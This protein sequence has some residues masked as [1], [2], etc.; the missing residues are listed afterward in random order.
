MHSS[1]AL[2]H[3]GHRAGADR[4]WL[5]LCDHA[6]HRI[7]AELGDLGLPAAEIC[8]HIG[9]DIGAL[10]LAQAIAAELQA[11]I[12]WHGWS[13]LV[14]DPNRHPHSADVVI[15]ESDGTPIPANLQLD[16]AA[17]DARIARYHTPYHAVIDAYLQAAKSA[18]E[19]PT[20]LA[21][22]SMTPR[23]RCEPRSRPMQASVLWL[24]DESGERLARPMIEHLRAQGLVVGDN[25]PYSCIELDTMGYTLDRHARQRGLPYLLIEVRQDL[26][27]G[28]AAIRRWAERL[29][30]GF[31]SVC[32]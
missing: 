20:L 6:T 32:R 23:L 2:E 7:P 24:D 19:L 17:R 10:D 21:I 5:V 31:D 1:L 30:A 27:D 22:H 15:P 11:P 9:W 29:S 13:R 28:P 12:F 4:R 3:Y 8:R 16:A 25:D 14:V 26:L 18:G